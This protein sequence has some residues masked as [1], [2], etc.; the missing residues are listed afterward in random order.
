MPT[1]TPNRE[2]RRAHALALKADAEDRLERTRAGLMSRRELAEMAEGMLEVL[3]IEL[4]ALKAGV[5]GLRHT[6]DLPVL[7]EQLAELV[8]AYR[9]RVAEHLTRNSDETVPE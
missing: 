1:R 4:P 6:A 3:E 2:G 5:R 7:M 8:R 9:L